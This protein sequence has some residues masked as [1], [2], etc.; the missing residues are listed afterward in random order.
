MENLDFL[1]KNL[2]RRFPIRQDS[3]L[4]STSGL[5]LSDDVITGGRFTVS[6]TTTILFISSISFNNGLVKVVISTILPSDRFV[7]LGCASGQIT[8]DYQRL[9]FTPLDSFFSGYIIMG[10]KST[11]DSLNSTYEFTASNYSEGDNSARIEDS[12]VTRFS[13]PLV[14]SI[15]SS[16]TTKTGAIALTYSNIKE[17]PDAALPILNLTLIDKTGL[18]L[19]GDLSSAFDNCSNAGIKT[20]NGVTPDANGN[21]DIY[22]I[23][24]VE[25]SINLITKSIGV[26]VKDL[27]LLKLCDK[28]NLTPPNKKQNNYNDV[29]TVTE[30]EWRK[31]PNG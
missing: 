6:T 31:W 21:I 23:E 13:Y 20:I 2:Y 26:K 27:T 11:I 29:L 16:D 5:Q 14:S 8:E 17:T 18:Y 12:L 24:P 9:I 25:L 10:L 15:E 28:N 1:N 22:S 19:T 30:E 3:T 7:V 4:L